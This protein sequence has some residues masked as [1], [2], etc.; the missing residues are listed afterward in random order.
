MRYSERVHLIKVTETETAL[1]LSVTEEVT[2]CPCA[3]QNLSLQEQ[4]GIYGK[5]MGSTVKL[6]VP[7]PASEYTK[8]LFQGKAYS[9]S[10]VKTFG[11]T[12]VLY[13]VGA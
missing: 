10:V 12:S 1:G 7:I 4:T 2:E 3:S 11:R 8:A 6:H 5:V 13:L 9:V